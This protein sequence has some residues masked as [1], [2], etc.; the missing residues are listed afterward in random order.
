MS[1]PPAGDGP[2]PNWYPDP[3]IPGYIR[4]WNGTS[5]VPGSSRPEP[6]EGEP[7]PTP[8][9]GS[10]NP[11]PGPAQDPPKHETQPFFFDEDSLPAAAGGDAG[12][13]LIPDQ[14][15]GSSLPELRRRGDVA[16]A[17]GGAA[18]AGGG[19]QRAPWGSDEDVSASPS[20]AVAQGSDPRSPFGRT[21]ADGAAVPGQGHQEP[22][23]DAPEVTDPQT[24]ALRRT[25]SG[26]SWERQV[27]DL[28]RQAPGTPA[29]GGPVPPAQASPPQGVP[30]LGL[31]GAAVPPQNAGPQPGH[32]SPPQGIPAQTGPPPGYGY[33][34]PGAQ[35]PG[36]PPGGYGFPHPQQAGPGGYGYPPPVQPGGQ[37][38]YGYPPQ[39]AN[40]SQSP[41]LQS[42][43]GA[44]LTMTGRL[45]DPGRPYPAKLGR[46]L[47]ARIVD[48]LLP[49][50]VAAA[51]AWPLLGSARDHIQDQIDAAERAGVT[52]QIWLV[53]GTTGG[54][55]A[56]VLGVFLV[57][58]LLFEALPTAIWGTTPGKGMVGARVLDL[59]N[60]EKPSFGAALLRW[61]VFNASALFVVGV[62]S[63]V[64][65]ARD[66]PWRQAWH[67]KAAKTFVAGKRNGEPE[68]ARN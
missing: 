49:T 33:P 1:S 46:R 61:L 24:A 43:E 58:G 45:V 21:P 16:P 18:W 37:G 3:S 32:V 10:A 14:A 50:A 62:V 40:P 34:Q 15:S 59:Q 19:D 9:S 25:E 44:P 36:T 48:T 67:D 27:H 26:G 60:Q 20:A 53:D 64:M 47:L 65:G 52:R 42:H 51:V 5:W 28:A 68:P 4:Y 66:K 54:Y 39:A 30:G 17:A 63:L 12:E 29:Q 31:P 35:Q 57:V 7:V 41:F 56:L 11:A 6:R 8:P 13:R 55:I 2:G 38:G 22:R 23:A